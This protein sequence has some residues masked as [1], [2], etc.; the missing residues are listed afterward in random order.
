MKA[1]GVDIRGFPDFVSDLLRMD[2]M[3]DL[4]V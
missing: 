4:S 1:H 2:S 3:L